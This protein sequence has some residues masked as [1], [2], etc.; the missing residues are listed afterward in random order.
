MLA[1]GPVR[2]PVMP[3]LERHVFVCENVRDPANERGCCAAKGA[4]EIRSRLRILAKQAGSATVIYEFGNV[5]MSL[6]ALLTVLIWHTAFSRSKYK[7]PQEAGRD[8]HSNVSA[9]STHLAG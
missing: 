2:L 3:P 5:L 4:E 8:A 6:S 9:S 1:R 7:A